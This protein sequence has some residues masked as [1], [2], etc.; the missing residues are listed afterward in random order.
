M[1]YHVIEVSSTADMQQ[2][3]NISA[4]DGNSRNNMSDALPK[5]A[6]THGRDLSRTV[7]FR[8]VL[9]RFCPDVSRNMVQQTCN[10]LATFGSNMQHR[11]RCERSLQAER[12][13]TDAPLLSYGGKHKEGIR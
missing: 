5:S 9:S 12:A 7:P 3:S 11:Q 1:Y 6:D 8:D 10:I 2:I 13:S 4:T